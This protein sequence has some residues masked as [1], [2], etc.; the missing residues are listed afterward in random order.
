[1]VSTPASQYP[2]CSA[3]VS[4]SVTAAMMPDP[5]HRAET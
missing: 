5:L 2:D 1:M 4:E 3:I